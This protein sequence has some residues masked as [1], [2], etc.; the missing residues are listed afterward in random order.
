MVD[1]KSKTN[2]AQMT[3]SVLEDGYALVQE[4]VDGGED[5]D[6]RIFLLEGKILDATVSRP[7]SGECLPVTTPGPTS[8]RADVLSRSRSVTWNAASSKR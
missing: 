6:A 5:G 8:A 2:L 7:P 3:E 4:F 1:D